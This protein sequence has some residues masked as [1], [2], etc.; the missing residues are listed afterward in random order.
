[1]RL[2]FPSRGLYYCTTCRREMLLGASDAAAAGALR[3]GAA[4]TPA[5]SLPHPT[6]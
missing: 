4:A 6:T 3:L 5:G 1:M 2:V